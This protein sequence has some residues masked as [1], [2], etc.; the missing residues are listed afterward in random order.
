MHLWSEGVLCSVPEAVG[1]GITLQRLGCIKTFLI[2]VLL[3]QTLS[4]EK[5]IFYFFFL[6]VFFFLDICPRLTFTSVTDGVVVE[7]ASIS[8]CPQQVIGQEGYI[9]GYI[10]R[11]ICCLYV[12]LDFLR[13]AEPSWKRTG[14]LLSAWQCS[15]H[16]LGLDPCSTLQS[17]GCVRQRQR[18]YLTWKGNWWDHT[19]A[20][21]DFTHSSVACPCLCDCRQAQ[22]PELVWVTAKDKDWG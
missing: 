22:A 15:L 19:K 18:V 13:N 6:F 3:N 1:D 16:V 7:V 12:R 10:F 9:C 5:V 17:P 14:C 11:Y 8:T 4:P 2:Q 20:L 21:W